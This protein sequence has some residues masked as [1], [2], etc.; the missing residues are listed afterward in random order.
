LLS[1]D[2]PFIMRRA[3]AIKQQ[4][5]QS[6]VK[7]HAITRRSKEQHVRAMM[8]N[9]PSR[10]VVPSTSQQAANQ[11]LKQEEAKRPV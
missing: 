5:E 1:D 7:Q 8:V 11:K 2:T 10:P 4:Q 6:K 9:G 3:A